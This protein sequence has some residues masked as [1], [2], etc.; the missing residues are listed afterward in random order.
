MF[1]L[2]SKLYFTNLIHSIRLYRVSISS[3]LV[4]GIHCLSPS[5]KRRCVSITAVQRP[6]LSRPMCPG[7]IHR[8]VDLATYTCGIYFFRIVV[9]YIITFTCCKSRLCL[10]FKNIIDSRRNSTE[11]AYYISSR[12]LKGYDESANTLDMF[13]YRKE[14]VHIIVSR[15]T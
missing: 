3:F 10:I 12:H 14:I 7:M 6:S 8:R 15:I 9:L 5:L 11:I 2:V 4:I 13:Q 1:Q